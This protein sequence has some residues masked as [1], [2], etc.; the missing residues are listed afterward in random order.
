MVPE[1]LM[2][3]VLRMPRLWAFYKLV[4]TV[5]LTAEWAGQ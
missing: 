4:L 2:L 5:I 3:V 1:I